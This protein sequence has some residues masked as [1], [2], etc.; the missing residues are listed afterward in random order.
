MLHSEDEWLVSW[1][2]SGKGRGF[3]DPSANQ[4]SG[5]RGLT[6]K[7]PWN[8]FCAPWVAWENPFAQCN[9][10][11]SLAIRQY[12]SLWYRRWNTIVNG[13]NFI[14]SFFWIFELQRSL[15]SSWVRLTSVL[16]SVYACEK[17]EA[18]LNQECQQGLLHM[19]SFMHEMRH[20]TRTAQEDEFICEIGI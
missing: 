6:A 7:R 4:W 5:G 8:E 16:V 20:T 2:I 11:R 1:P 10:G 13:S 12:R 17:K 18:L 3:W 9:L 19:S 15:F 14:W